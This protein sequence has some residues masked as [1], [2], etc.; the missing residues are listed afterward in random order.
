M[1]KSVES[2]KFVINLVKNVI[3]ICQKQGFKLTKC[4]SNS[5]EILT[6]IPEKRHH[7]KIKD[8]YLNIG[9]LSVKR[10]LGVHR[11]IENDN[12]GFKINLKDKPLTRRRMLSTIN[13]VYMIHMG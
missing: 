11:N 9:D 8:Q 10:A 5:R 4:I 1:V 7:Q 3:G 6:N 12:L 2:K 13:S